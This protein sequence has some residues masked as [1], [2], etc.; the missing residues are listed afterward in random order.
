MD[1]L[2]R[3]LFLIVFV[4]G[5]VSFTAAIGAEFRGSAGLP[6]WARSC[7]SPGRAATSMGRVLR[8]LVFIVLTAFSPVLM[9][10]VLADSLRDGDVVSALAS[11]I[12]LAASIA[13]LAFL[14]RWLRWSP[15]IAERG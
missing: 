14:L 2:S 6:R 4:F 3:A 9:F 1:S 10:A 7:V 12:A 13:W 15:S 8:S 11:T 5:F